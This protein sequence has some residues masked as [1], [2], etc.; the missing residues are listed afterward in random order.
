MY[1]SVHVHAGHVAMIEQE[2]NSGEDILQELFGTSESL[3]LTK[4]LFDNDY[5]GQ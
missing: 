1:W 4:E 2:R 5:L 3:S